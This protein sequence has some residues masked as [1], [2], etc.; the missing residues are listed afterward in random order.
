[1]HSGLT[2]GMYAPPCL[3]SWD[4]VLLIF[5]PGCHWLAVLPISVSQVTGIIGV[6][7]VAWPI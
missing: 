4:G 6:S 1:M 3:F 7:R 2:T 5:C